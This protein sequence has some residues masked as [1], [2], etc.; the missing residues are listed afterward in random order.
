MLFVKKEVSQAFSTRELLL[1]FRVLLCRH[2]FPLDT[3]SA[4]TFDLSD[5]G[6]LN[7]ILELDSI[8]RFMNCGSTLSVA[9]RVVVIAS[10]Q[11]QFNVSYLQ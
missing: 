11:A 7:E 8:S 2:I 4:I 10:P 9:G 5:L 3:S 6:R 1:K